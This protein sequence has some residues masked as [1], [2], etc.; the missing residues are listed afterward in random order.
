M[1]GII[2][3]SVN[4]IPKACIMNYSYLIFGDCSF[5]LSPLILLVVIYYCLQCPLGASLM[6]NN[7]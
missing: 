4:V 6:V 1:L 5:Y 3:D 7:H 2:T